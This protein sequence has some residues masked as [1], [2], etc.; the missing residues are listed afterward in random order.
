V[1]LTVGV[2]VATGE[3]VTVGTGVTLGVTVGCEAPANQALSTPCQAVLPDRQSVRD[4][5]WQPHE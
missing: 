5:S 4:P 1:A 2:G 3:R